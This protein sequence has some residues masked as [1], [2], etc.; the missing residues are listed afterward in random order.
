MTTT[1]KLLTADDLLA[2][3]R[4]G[5]RHELVR[6]EL[7]TMPPPGFM[8]TIVTDNFG[9]H[10]RSFV[11]QNGLPY[12]GG[13]EAAA[14]IEQSPDTVRAADYAFYSRHDLPSPLPE[15]GY[16][17]GLVPVLAVEVI[18]PGYRSA[19]GVA[20]RV[21]MWLEAGVQLVVVAHIAT[22]EI[23][24]YGSDGTEHTFNAGDTL[25]LEP[26][27]PGFACPVDDLFAF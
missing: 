11:R 5:Y 24:T 13:P 15:R 23:V 14:Y 17:T 12:V 20:E 3:P 25:T 7:I 26:A 18:S 6:G 8:H 2:M 22:R 21:R 19:A 16:V 27:L 4:D 10:T 9:F 1:R